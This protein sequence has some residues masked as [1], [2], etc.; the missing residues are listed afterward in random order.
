MG[1][2]PGLWPLG[3]AISLVIML[4]A[5]STLNHERLAR[6]FPGI[7]GHLG[8]PHIDVTKQKYSIPSTPAAEADR[9]PTADNQDV[10]PPKDSFH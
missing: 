7:F 8:P 5:R 1:I 2:Q 6:D 3:I 10:W 4:I 9:I